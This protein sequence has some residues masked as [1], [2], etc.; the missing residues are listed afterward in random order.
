MKEL[1]PGSGLGPEQNGLSP[2]EREALMAR[3]KGSNGQGL[4]SEQLTAP[5]Q[6]THVGVDGRVY[7]YQVKEAS[8]EAH[9]GFQSWL[10]EKGRMDTSLAAEGI[11]NGINPTSET[12]AAQFET[13]PTKTIVFTAPEPPKKYP[14]IGGD[15]DKN[16][17]VAKPTQEQL[18][19]FERWYQEERNK[20]VKS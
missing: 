5:K 11:Q 13:I 8:P 15:K 10:I 20:K 16:E 19:D 18:D 3:F 2:N 4:V 17:M 1:G 12:A 7:N 14:A 9:Q 6:R